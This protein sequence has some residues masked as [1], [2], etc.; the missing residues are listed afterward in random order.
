MNMW[1]LVR[2]QV[3]WRLAGD[4]HMNKSILKSVSR[5]LLIKV[6]LNNISYTLNLQLCTAS[7]VVHVAL[8]LGMPRST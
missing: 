3:H 1:M 6:I 4:P 7:H 5:N 8:R 2:E